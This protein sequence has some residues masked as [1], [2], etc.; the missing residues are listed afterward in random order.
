MNQGSLIYFAIYLPIALTQSY[1]RKTFR[2][3]PPIVY[4]HGQF[5]SRNVNFK[6]F[7]YHVREIFNILLHIG[8][9]VDCSLIFITIRVFFYKQT[10][11]LY[12]HPLPEP[13]KTS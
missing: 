7:P 9:L 12:L 6:T 2:R 11:L 10:V 5:S 4:F 13:P 3:Y 1:M 8:C